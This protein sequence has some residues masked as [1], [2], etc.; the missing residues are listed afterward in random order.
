MFNFQN[1][2]RVRGVR[3]RQQIE[4]NRRL[5]LLKVRHLLVERAH[6]RQRHG[7]LAGTFVQLDRLQNTVVELRPH[8]QVVHVLRAPSLVFGSRTRVEHCVFKKEII[9]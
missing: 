8:V 2:R 5:E 1:L 4:S 7:R 6:V 9:S 3:N